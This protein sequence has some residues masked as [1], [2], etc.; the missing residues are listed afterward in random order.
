MV[1]VG[2]IIKEKADADNDDD[3]AGAGDGDGSD[4]EESE[5]LIFTDSRPNT[6]APDAAMHA[7][8]PLHVLFL[9]S[10]SP[11]LSTSMSIMTSCDADAMFA[12]AAAGAAQGSTAPNG[13]VVDTLV[14][15]LLPA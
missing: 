14:P 7:A 15:L 1:S 6:A 11:S 2:L 4:R 9:P 10:S 13:G 3:G 5:A 12:V 8:F